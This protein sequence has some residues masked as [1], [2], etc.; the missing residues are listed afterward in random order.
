MVP[1]EGV[2]M[3]GENYDIKPC[4]CGRIPRVV[5]F[6]DPWADGACYI[7]CECGMMVR[8]IDRENE[9]EAKRVAIG[10]WNRGVTP[11]KIRLVGSDV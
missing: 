9:D 8:R 10:I 4:G 1:A 5:A 2:F 6:D 11:S 3:D 7:E